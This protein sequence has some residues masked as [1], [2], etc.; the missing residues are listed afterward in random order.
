MVFS[1]EEEKNNNPHP[2]DNVDIEKKFIILAL[3]SLKIIVK[4]SEERHAV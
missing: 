2:D 4:I 1:G 3:D